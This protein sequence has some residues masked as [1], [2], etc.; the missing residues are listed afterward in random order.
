[1]NDDDDEEDDKD[2]GLFNME[3]YN[4]LMD[5]AKKTHYLLNNYI[6]SLYKIEKEGTWKV[7]HPRKNKK[8][9]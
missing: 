5:L 7:I 1:M 8:A 6:R 3:T 4:E 2:D 9:T